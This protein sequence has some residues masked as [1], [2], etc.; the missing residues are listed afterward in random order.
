MTT[1]LPECK[2]LS[3]DGRLIMLRRVVHRNPSS[4]RGQRQAAT[5]GVVR[6]GGRVQ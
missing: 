1:K 5:D 2:G 4:P 6:L 3:D